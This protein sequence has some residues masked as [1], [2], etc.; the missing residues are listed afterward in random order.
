MLGAHA[1]YVKFYMVNNS[2]VTVL[3]R[4]TSCIG[5]NVHFD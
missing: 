4:T 1:M 2:L 5:D 3:L